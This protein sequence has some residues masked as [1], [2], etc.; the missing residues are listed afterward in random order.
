M[1][2]RKNDTELRL[3]DEC[4]RL[5]WQILQELAKQVQAGVTT[6]ELDQSAER[7]ARQVHGQP[8][9]K[10]YRGFPASLC[11]SVND[12]IVHGIPS[13][14]RLKEGDIVSLDFGLLMGG[15]YGDAALTVPVGEV[16]EEAQRLLRVTEEALCR[17]IKAAV[18]GNHLGDVSWE[19]QT[20]VENSGFSVVREFV[21]HGIG[22]SLHEEPQVPNYGNPG[23]GPRLEQGMVLA[24]EP[25]VNVGSAQVLLDPDRW[26]ARTADHSLSAH[27]ERSVAI[28]SNGPWTLG[29]DRNKEP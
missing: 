19:V 18:A 16:L 13:D 1:I 27:F 9:F 14:R 4:N 5:N 25:M 26:T 11:A 28:T 6:R 8:A 29:G 22:T 17:A 2:I 23:Q 7:L 24:I 3:M 15:Y 21:G 10:G 20:F 12:E